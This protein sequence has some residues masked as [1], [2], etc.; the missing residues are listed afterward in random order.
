MLF[1]FIGSID[2]KDVIN[3]VEII[4]A[5]NFLNKYHGRERRYNATNYRSIT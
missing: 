4:Q 2:E 1:D 3:M 5:H